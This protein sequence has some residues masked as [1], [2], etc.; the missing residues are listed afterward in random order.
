MNA[1]KKGAA[2]TSVAPAAT[3][4]GNDGRKGYSSD[5]AGKV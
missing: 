2:L 3:Q 5:G 4:R 1:G